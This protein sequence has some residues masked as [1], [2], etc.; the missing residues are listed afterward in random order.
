MKS[1]DLSDED[2]GPEI[3]VYQSQL[4]GGP[5]DGF[6]MMLI[7]R[8]LTLFFQR[9]KHASDGHYFY[10]RTSKYEFQYRGIAE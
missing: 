9:T 10:V 6:R 1:V 4:C 7:D 5:F 3:R 2:F 8:Q